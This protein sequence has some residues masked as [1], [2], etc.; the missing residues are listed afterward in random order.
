M[1]QPDLRSLRS[2][3][4]FS[5]QH[6]LERNDAELVP[7]GHD[8]GSVY[9]EAG[10]SGLAMPRSQLRAPPRGALDNRRLN[11]TSTVVSRRAELHGSVPG[12]SD[13]EPTRSLQMLHESRQNAHTTDGG[14]PAVQYYGYWICDLYH[15][16][17]TNLVIGS[18]RVPL[19][20]FEEKQ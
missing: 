8:P 7:R 16:D 15:E 1:K 4:R 13:T 12:C 10:A 2:T 6:L 9:G 11:R 19:V 20:V 17:Q 3:R 5:H 18:G 14:S